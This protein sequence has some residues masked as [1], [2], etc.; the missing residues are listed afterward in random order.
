MLQQALNLL[1]PVIGQLLPVHWKRSHGSE[2]AVK[3]TLLSYK[4]RK[5]VFV[6]LATQC[7]WQLRILVAHGLY[8]HQLT[9]M[10]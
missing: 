2:V 4:Y 8:R 6:S 10:P 5:R 3:Q 9:R 1:C 7:L